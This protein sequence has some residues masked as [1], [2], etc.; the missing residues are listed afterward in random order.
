MPASTV[1]SLRVTRQLG[2]TGANEARQRCPELTSSMQ[3]A[4]EGAWRGSGKEDC[5]EGEVPLL[6]TA[7]MVA[8]WHAFLSHRGSFETLTVLV[9]GAVLGLQEMWSPR[10]TPEPHL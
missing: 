4:F 5:V 2:L 1:L 10:V 8:G 7:K 3:R 9:H 6:I